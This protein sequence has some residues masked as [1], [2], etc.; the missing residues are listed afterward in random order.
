MKKVHKPT[1][2]QENCIAL[3]KIKPMVK[4]IAAA[5]A[6]KTSTLE[7]ISK[8][9]IEDSLYLAFN[10]S[11]A[12]EA[13]ER[14]PAHVTCQTTHSLAFNVFGRALMNKLSRPQGKYVN[15]AGT[16]S[17]IAK[18]YKL[19]GISVAGETIV[20]ANALGVYVKRTVERF[21]QSADLK[22]TL[23]NV[24]S[25]DMEKAIEADKGIEKYV[26]K[27]AKKLWEDR[28]DLDSPVL[29][30][31]DTY[32]KLYQLSKPTLNYSVIYVDE[33]QDS[34]P[35]VLDI[36]MNQ[37]GTS[38]I[39]AVGDPFQAIYG[40]RGAVN[41][42]SMM[43]CVEAPLSMSFRY[44]NGI[45]EVATAVLSKKMV[46][47]G[48]E[49]LPSSIGFNVV[50][51]T[52]PYMYLFRTNA[53][54]LDKAVAAID[55][56]EKVKVEVDVK[57]FVKILQSAQSLFDASRCA[58]EAIMLKVNK[59]F[60]EAN[61]KNKEAEQYTKNIKHERIL[62]Y[63]S[64]KG[65]VEEAK[66][67]KGELKRLQGIIEGGRCAHI[68]SV[69]EGY[70]APPD[71]L[72]TYTTSHKA[73]GREAEQVILADDFPSHY[74]K[75]GEWKPLPEA[76]QNLLYVAVT[77]SQNVLEVNHSVV[78]VL[79]KYNIDY[80][81]GMWE[82]D[83]FYEDVNVDVGQQIAAQIRKESRAIDKIIHG[84]KYD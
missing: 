23:Q 4:I 44:G 57:D 9:L 37:A 43:E 15:V 51:R 66:E 21:E 13:T 27:F 32:L 2:Q 81:R 75:D 18:Y 77:R 84:G 55:A 22:I 45:A 40:W 29:A 41:A 6:G 10:K 16:G 60:A 53:M 82:D 7:L 42:L 49:D 83:S 63:G 34:T 67:I 26:L 73:K 14:F 17:E 47:S 65:L 71:A 79:D 1:G 64:W 33:Q 59:N 30:S 52:K 28:T 20:S 61:A 48:R 58:Q 80:K 72:A 31:H 74:G 24:P 78:E 38:K 56:G 12:V 3:S 62:P 19:C 11:T 35:C 70:V 25:Y 54:L 36:V 8:E 50:D 76:E 39:I 46:I 5:G 68:I 69:L